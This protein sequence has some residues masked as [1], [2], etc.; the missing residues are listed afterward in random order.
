MVIVGGYGAV[1][2]ALGNFQFKF[3]C[4]LLHQEYF[5]RELVQDVFGVLRISHWLV[6]EFKEL[7]LVLAV[8]IVRLDRHF[9]LPDLGISSFCEGG[10]AGYSH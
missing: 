10:L 4:E 2:P 7:P 8:Q 3:S 5:F 1:V 6:E 9:L